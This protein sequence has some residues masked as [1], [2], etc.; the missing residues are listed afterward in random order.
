MSPLVK[1][2]E[3]ELLFERFGG[4]MKESRLQVLREYRDAR[5]GRGKR[6]LGRRVWN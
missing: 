6:R 5:D 1:W 2:P 4:K 3:A